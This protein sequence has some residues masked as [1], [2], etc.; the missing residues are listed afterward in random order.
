MSNILEL[1]RLTK[2]YGSVTAIRDLT[3]HLTQN[4]IYGLLGRN[5][6]GKTTLLHILSAQ[7]FASSGEVKVLGEDPFENEQVLRQMC[8]VKES[9]KYPET[10]RVM[11]VLKVASALFPNWDGD[12]ANMLVNDFELP[13]QRNVR[14]LSRG[15]L[16]ALGVIVGLASR[17][18]ITIFDEPYLGLDAVARGIFYDRLLEDYEEHPRMIILSTHLIDEASRILE[19]VVLLEQGNVLINED[20]DQLRERAFTVVGTA[21][22]VESFLMGKNVVHLEEF[23]GL[24]KATLVN[25]REAGDCR[26]QAQELE[27]E[28]VPLSLQQLIVYLTNKKDERKVV[29]SR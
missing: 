12:Y 1:Q 5:G 18:P 28:V 13:L 17:A 20:V 23:G 8:F 21:S 7:L 6:A 3:L 9:Q 19:H 16:S 25:S 15:M 10:Y 29:E 24:L 14:K 22:K 4:K 11:D 2:S 27:L 26:Q